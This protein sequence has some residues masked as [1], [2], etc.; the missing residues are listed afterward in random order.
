MKKLILAGGQMRAPLL[1]YDLENKR[2]HIPA[3]P[4]C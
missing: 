2:A 4:L 1:C 3:N